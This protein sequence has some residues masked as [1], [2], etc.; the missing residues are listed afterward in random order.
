M[1]AALAFRTLFALA[2][3]LVVVTILVRAIAGV[4]EFL[5]I[6]NSLLDV[7]GWRTFASCYPSAAT[8][9][10]SCAAKRFANGW[11]HRRTNHASHLPAVG[12]IGFAMI[13]YAAITLLRTIENSFNV[14][15][16]APR[17]TGRAVAAFRSTGS[18]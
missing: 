12:W 17:R 4:D 10:K 6:V 11:P 8:R 9:G 14:I 15:Y 18:C 3:V 7:A 1:A 2:P 16:R 5:R 13:V